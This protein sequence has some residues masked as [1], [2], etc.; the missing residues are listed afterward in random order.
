MPQVTTIS[1]DSVPAVERD[2]IIDGSRVSMAMSWS[3]FHRAASLKRLLA[4]AKICEG[5]DLCN[6]DWMHLRRGPP[7]ADSN[8][9]SG[10]QA[11]LKDFDVPAWSTSQVGSTRTFPADCQTVPSPD[12]GSWP[13]PPI[14]GFLK[15]RGG[16]TDADIE[17]TF[18][19]SRYDCCP[20]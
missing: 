20:P 5:L 3:V 19:W 16:L 11:L 9:C 14:F 15:D 7:D 17:S 12:A 18:R 13:V 10:V 1:L 4:G 6:T 2:Q 8:L